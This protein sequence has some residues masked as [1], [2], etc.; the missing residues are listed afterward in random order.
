MAEGGIAGLL[1]GLG[2]T[3]VAFHAVH[4]RNCFDLERR[5]VDD[6]R[7]AAR[8]QERQWDVRQYRGATSP[9]AARISFFPGGI[10]SYLTTI[11]PTW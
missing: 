11:W 1:V 7:R 10:S 2:H 6:V 5:A 3:E 4:Q 9:Q 8:A